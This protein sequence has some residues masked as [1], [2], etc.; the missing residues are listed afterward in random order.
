MPAPESPPPGGLRGALQQVL[1]SLLD[2]GRTRIEL[3]AVELEEERLRLV[4]LWISATVTLFLAFVSVMLATALVVLLCEPAQRVTALGA[5]LAGFTAAGLV[6]AGYWRHL[7]RS[8]PPLLQATLEQL[9]Q[10]RR[11][12]PAAGGP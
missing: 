7:A 8:R 9:Q 4:T 3:A 10:D 1:G 11:S 12:L 5:L 2:I 6:A